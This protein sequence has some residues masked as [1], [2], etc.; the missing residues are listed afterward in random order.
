MD[1]KNLSKKEKEKVKKIKS[2][3]RLALAKKLGS[4][5]KLGDNLSKKKIKRKNKFSLQA[6][7]STK[8]KSGMTCQ[9]AS[10]STSGLFMYIDMHGHANKRGMLYVML[11][12]ED[13]TKYSSLISIPFKSC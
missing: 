7:S 2:Q 6:R 4:N 1:D 9:S 11:I 3:E 13:F 8:L 5:E 12:Y 10:E